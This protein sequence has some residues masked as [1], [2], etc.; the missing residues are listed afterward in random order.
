[1]CLKILERKLIQAFT[2]EQAVRVYLFN[3]AGFDVP[4]ISKTD[5]NELLR[6]CS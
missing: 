2:K 3:K 4:G 1:M 5:L 6:Y